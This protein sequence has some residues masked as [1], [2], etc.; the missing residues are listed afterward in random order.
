VKA[1][2]YKASKSAMQ[3]G[4]VKTGWILESS[5]KD[6]YI[7]TFMGWV[8]SK[9]MDQQVKMHFDTEEEAINFAI[10]KDWEYE[11]VEPQVRKI[12]PK[13]YADNFK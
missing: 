13:S 2:I 1:I 9:N 7:E 10:S 5:E 11:F 3:S 8:G 12:K 4:I 6:N